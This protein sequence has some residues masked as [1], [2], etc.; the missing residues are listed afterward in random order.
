MNLKTLKKT[1]E[2]VVR[3]IMVNIFRVIVTSLFGNY[4]Q[5]K[6]TAENVDDALRE[7]PDANMVKNISPFYFYR[8]NS[9]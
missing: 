3:F 7:L 9:F 6:K 2:S 1:A 8:L 5:V 4:L